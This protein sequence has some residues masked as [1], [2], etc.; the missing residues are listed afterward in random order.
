MDLSNRLPPTLA[1]WLP[2]LGAAL[3]A[4][5]LAELAYRIGERIVRRAVR[6]SMAASRVVEAARRP[7]HWVLPLVALNLVWQGTPDELAGI[8]SVQHL[9]MLLLIGA[10]T[11][12]AVSCITGLAQA[13]IEA[14]P[15]TVADNLDARRIQTQSRVLSRILC[16]LVLLIGASIML[17]SF[18][19]VRQIGTSLLASAGLVGIVAGFAARPVLGNLIAGLQIGLSQPIRLDDVV[20]VEG[21]WGV[22]EEITGT[23]V[24]V[25]IWDQRRLVVPL[26]WWIEHPFQNWTRSSAELIGTVFLWVD[27][28]MPLA[29]LRDALQ[30]A[31]KASKDW[32]GRLALLQVTDANAQAI[33]LRALVTS[34]N[35][36]KNWDL[37]CHVRERLIDFVQRGYPQY[38]PRLRAEAALEGLE[39]TPAGG[40][41]RRATAPTASASPSAL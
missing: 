24:V 18:P 37:R 32:D 40:A 15:V 7:A 25:R 4:L 39:A 6:H 29:P 1:D 17:M 5:L 23:Y 31:C 21:E 38:L 10:L 2:V 13:V 28:R 33:Q 19:A 12:L 3:V 8:G 30:A 36:S 9:T 41:T 16:A 35:S 26:Q 34:V 27:Y 20:I 14:H 11:W 22:I